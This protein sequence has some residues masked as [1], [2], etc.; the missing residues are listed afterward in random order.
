[1]IHKSVVIELC[2]ELGEQLLA[3][4]GHHH[5][6][7]VTLLFPQPDLPV[8]EQLAQKRHKLAWK[9]L[10]AIE[11]RRVVHDDV[12]VPDSSQRLQQSGFV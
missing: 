9:R 6:Q 12:P 7:F 3:S 4:G 1:L 8:R 5:L 11:E 10:S 2:L